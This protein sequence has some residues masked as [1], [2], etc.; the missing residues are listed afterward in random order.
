M[1]GAY[2]VAYQSQ[3]LL[4]I[5]VDFYGSCFPHYSLSLLNA[6]LI[7]NPKRANVTA[8][9][10]K[11]VNMSHLSLRT[12]VYMSR[13]PAFPAEYMLSVLQKRAETDDR[14]MNG[15]IIYELQMKKNRIVELE[16]HTGPA[17]AV[18]Q[19]DLTIGFITP[20]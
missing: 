5:F 6:W 12:I 10:V 18:C 7:P 4:E 1:Y 20:F 3:K 16:H 17:Y 13:S 11:K 8:T 14:S 9:L 2:S 15:V 19:F